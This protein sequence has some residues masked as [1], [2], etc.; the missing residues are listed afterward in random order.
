MQS[1]FFM[2]VCLRTVVNVLIMP[3]V[4]P[5]WI[6]RKKFSFIWLWYK[7]VPFMKVKFRS[8]LEIKHLNCIQS[9][10]SKYYFD[11]MKYLIYIETP[12][13]IFSILLYNNDVL[14]QDLWP[15]YDVNF[16]LVAIFI[17]IGVT[18]NVLLWCK[19]IYFM[20][21]YVILSCSKLFHRVY[22][23]HS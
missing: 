15:V 18:T 2:H 10:S 6:G 20:T 5:N 16:S 22:F 12:C 9:F 19:I 3:V 21:I 1:S 11:M 23:I 8:K 7:I 4:M 13:C 17:W 14:S